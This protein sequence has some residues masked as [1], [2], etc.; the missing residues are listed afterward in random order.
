MSYQG[1]RNRRTRR[2]NRGGVG[3]LQ[4]SSSLDLPGPLAFLGNPKLFAII[5]LIAGGSMVFFLFA[6]ALGIGRNSSNNTAADQQM[7]EAAD[8]PVGDGSPTPTNGTPAPDTSSSDAQTSVKRYT[9]APAMAIDTSKTYTATIQT[10]KGTIQIELYADAAP[11]AVNAFVFLAS[12]GYYDNTQFMELTK[13]GDGNKFY[14]QAGDPTETGLGTPGFSIPK[15]LTD[16]P[17]AR[18][19]VGMGGSAENSNGGQFFISFGDYPT[20]DGKYTIFGKVTSGLD[21]LDQLSLLDLTSGQAGSTPGDEIQ[22]ITI[23]E[24]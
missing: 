17:F 11:Q 1:N 19:Y 4:S 15:E 13:D 12:D 10:T 8:V 7:N 22:S 21:V 24:Q 23:A 3:D 18:G 2:D 16:Y 5:A 6:G 20:L 14:A 9:A